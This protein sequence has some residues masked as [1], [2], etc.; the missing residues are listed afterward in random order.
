L[1][2]RINGGAKT[3]ETIVVARVG[4][5]LIVFNTRDETSGAPE[6]I[7]SDQMTAAVNKLHSAGIPS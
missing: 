6:I 7:D 1:D 2:V 5:A 3:V 4:G